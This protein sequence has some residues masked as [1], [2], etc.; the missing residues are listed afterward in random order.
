MRYKHVG[1]AQSDS[2]RAGGQADRPI[3]LKAAK[4]LLA[5]SGGR[6]V[7]PETAITRSIRDLLRLLRVPHFKHHGG[8][9]SERG[10]PDLIGHLPPS[11]R[12]LYIEVK[13]EK[14][15]SSEEQEAFLQQAAESGAVAVVARSPRDVL[16]VLRAIGY[17][18]ALRVML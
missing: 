6:R 16:D 12:A 9:G 13:T 17:V 18:P 14:G 15:R 11:G 10:V 5:R 3:G 8:L 4:A 7:N 2:G 1:A